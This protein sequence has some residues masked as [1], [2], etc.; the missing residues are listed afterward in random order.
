[1][2]DIIKKRNTKSCGCKVSIASNRFYNIW[3][4]M[5][6]RCTNPFV[7]RYKD[8]GAR[9]ITICEEWLDVVAFISWAESTHPNVE[10]YSLDRIDND[11]GYSPE[12]CR[13]ADATTQCVNQRI[14]KDNTSGFVGVIWHKIVGRWYAQININNKK[15]NIGSYKTIEEAVLARDNYITQNNLPHKLSTDYVREIK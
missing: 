4:A 9:G 5:I 2:E 1:M 14:R 11:K 3:N 6:Q 8:Y 7:E 12:N 10:G 15:M 13:W